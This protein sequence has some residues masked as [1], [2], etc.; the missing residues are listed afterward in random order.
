MKSILIT[1]AGGN[2]GRAVI[3]EMARDHY[4]HA[5]L[6]PGEDAKFFIE[7][8]S[9]SNIETTFINLMDELACEA[10]V[11][12]VAQNT[13]DIITAAILLVGGWQKGNLEDTHLTDLDKM[14]KLNFATAFN[15]VKPLVEYFKK[16]GIGRFIFIG[17]R[18]AINVNEA[19][20]QF[21]YAI[22]KSMVIKMAEIINQTS[23]KYNIQAHV[24]I[25][26]VLDT[27]QNRLAMPDANPAD[28]VQPDHI[29]QTI[30]FLLSDPAN[31]FRD[32]LLKIYNKA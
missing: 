22:S 26:S 18:P 16:T 29:A 31:D 13:N 27:P 9:K 12:N 25:P 8:P 30:R 14:I 32:T 4:L 19:K 5:A 2:L 17:A 28:W 21:A 23:A 11:A 1:G 24:I 6:G 3:N 20:E 7:H 15:V 10:Y